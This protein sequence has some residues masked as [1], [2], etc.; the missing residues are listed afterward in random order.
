MHTHTYVLLFISTK[1][2]A[3]QGISTAKTMIIITKK[4]LPIPSDG[5][6]FRLIGIPCAGRETNRTAELLS[7]SCATRP[8]RDHFATDSVRAKLSSLF[9]IVSPVTRLA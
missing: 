3:Q 6:I 7:A 8:S 5:I 9:A 1:E 4:I 2:K